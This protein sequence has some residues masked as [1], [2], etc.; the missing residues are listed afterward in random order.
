MKKWKHP[1]PWLW[2]IPPKSCHVTLEF[3]DTKAIE[4]SQLQ[5]L[6]WVEGNQ[7][8]SPGPCVQIFRIWPSR[9]FFN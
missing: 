2:Y 7:I 4:N 3:A 6:W 1:S 5:Q 9:Q 8:D